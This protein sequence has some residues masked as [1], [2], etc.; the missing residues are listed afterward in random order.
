MKKN[1]TCPKQKVISQDTESNNGS[2]FFNVFKILFI[3]FFFFFF[4]WGGGERSE[5][6]GKH[7]EI[8]T[9]P[10]LIHDYFFAFMHCSNILFQTRLSFAPGNQIHVH[11]CQQAAPWSRNLG[12]NVYRQIHEFGSTF[13]EC[14]NTYPSIV[15][16]LIGPQVCG[17]WTFFLSL[18]FCGATKPP[19][20]LNWRAV[21][22]TIFMMK[23]IN[24]Y[25]TYSVHLHQ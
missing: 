18:R 24:L 22:K 3:Y 7:S 8:L 11:A 16:L 6:R 17:I 9:S 5:V 4:F 21:Q 12:S 25:Q 14:Q 10:I 1:L 2:H 13:Q 15:L 19:F 20:W 23:N